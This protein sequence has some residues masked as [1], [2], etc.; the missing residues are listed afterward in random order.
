MQNPI[1]SLLESKQLLVVCILYSLFITIIFLLPSKEIQE[2][3][4]TFIPIDKLVHVFIFLVLTFLWLLYVNSVLNDTKPI[5]LFF[6]LAVCLL[7]GILIEVIQ[8]HYLSSRGAEVLDVIADIL[9]ASLGLLFFRN[10]KNRITS[11]F[12]LFTQ[13]IIYF[14]N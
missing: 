3:F 11:L 1:K 7:Y 4:D 2:L 8:E 6:I 9:G 14:S 5:A 13:E 10:Y 12:F